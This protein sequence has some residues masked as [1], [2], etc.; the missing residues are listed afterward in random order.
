[1]AVPRI[2]ETAMAKARAKK[3]SL[4]KSVGGVKVP[5]ALRKARPLGKL[6]KS[7]LGREILADVIVAAAGAAAAA[8]S[9]TGAG[10]SAGRA[11]TNL[12][13]AAAEAGGDAARAGSQ[14]AETATGAVAGVVTEAA[15]SLL[16]SSLVGE[17]EERPRYMSKSSGLESRKRSKPAQAEG[18]KRKKKK[19]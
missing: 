18:R 1:M 2:E 4:P 5:K 8:L 12:G 7:D 6:M 15:R 19:R 17:G 16:P 9:R 11:V 10:R 13:G 3:A 14:L